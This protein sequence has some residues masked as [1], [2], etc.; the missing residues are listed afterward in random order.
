MPS[1]IFQPLKGQHQ[2]RI[3]KDKTGQQIPYSSMCV[4][5]VN[6]LLFVCFLWR[7]GPTRAMASSFTRFLHH[8]QR[9]ITV[10]RTPLD[11]WSASRTDLYLTT[12]NTHNRQTSIGLLWT[13]DQP[14]AQTSTWQHSQQTD[15]HA[16]G[17]IRTPQSLQ[18]SG[19]RPTSHPATTANSWLILNPRNNMGQTIN[20]AADFRLVIYSVWLILYRFSTSR[21]MCHRSTDWAALIG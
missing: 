4:C 9:R 14:V 3:H 12:H 11:E 15:I 17:G 1:Y 2:G 8:T 5:R 19:P 16:P 20:M 7:C 6:M 13:S 18:D 21:C 10:G